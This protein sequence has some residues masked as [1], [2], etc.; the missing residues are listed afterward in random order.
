M[1]KL[2]DDEISTTSQKGDDDPLGLL[3]DP[4]SLTEYLQ[5]HGENDVSAFEQFDDADTEHHGLDPK[6]FGNL[7]VPSPPDNWENTVK[8]QTHSSRGCPPFEEVDNPGG[9]HPY[10]YQPK[11]VG[12][13][14]SDK[15]KG[16]YLPTGATVCPPSTIKGREMSPTIKIPMSECIKTGDSSTKGSNL[17]KPFV[18]VQAEICLLY[19]SD[20][21]DE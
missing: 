13:K 16:H 11:Y 4:Q 17:Q 8:K 15:Y 9:W 14:S 21:A 6:L 19:T 20:A 1:D 10:V 3:Q 12:R 5:T 18:L 7:K 2:S